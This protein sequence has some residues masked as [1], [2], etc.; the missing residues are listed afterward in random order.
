MLLIIA[1]ICQV[2]NMCQE[3]YFMYIISLNPHYKWVALHSAHYMLDTASQGLIQLVWS[4]LQL[5]VVNT[6]MIIFILQMKRP[7][8]RAVSN[9]SKP[10]S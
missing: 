6:V 4:S 9:C 5:S 1:P 10:Q 2:F 7:R 3:L 8:H